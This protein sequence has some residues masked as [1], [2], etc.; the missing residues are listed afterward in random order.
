MA[1]WRR[2]VQLGE[3]LRSSCST[4]SPDERSSMADVVSIDAASIAVDTPGS[5]GRSSKQFNPLREA[6]LRPGEGA[7]IFLFFLYT[8]R[9]GRTPTG[10]P[11]TQQPSEPD[12]RG[13]EQGAAVVERT[14]APVYSCALARQTGIWLVSA[15]APWLLFAVSFV[16][17][18]ALSH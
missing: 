5:S 10:R 7:A 6:V 8:W 4:C 16:C 15:T 2:W 17:A 9:G 11:H 3:K 13:P 14:D 12:C 1:A 18:S